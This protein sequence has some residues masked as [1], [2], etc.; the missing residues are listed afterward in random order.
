MAMITLD[1]I[2]YGAPMHKNSDSVSC[3]YK[4]FSDETAFSTIT[5]DDPS[6]IPL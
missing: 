3:A 1:A 4:T 6:W 5:Y 2:L